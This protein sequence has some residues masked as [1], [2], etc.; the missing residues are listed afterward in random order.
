M[1]AD[2]QLA[3]YAKLTLQKNLEGRY[4]ERALRSRILQTIRTDPS[5]AALVESGAAQLREWL[6]SG[7]DDEKETRL[8]PIHKM[9]LEELTADVFV[10]TTT[11]FRPETL[12]GVASRV[13]HKLGF[14]DTADAVKTAAEIIT[15]LSY[16]GAFLL[17]KPSKYAQWFVTNNLAMPAE[18]I[19]MADRVMFIL[20]M[21]SRPEPI[22][23]A[24]HS[25]YETFNETV[26]TGKAELTHK[27]EIGIDV[28]NTQNQVA[29]SIDEEFL[30]VCEEKPPTDLDDVDDA[31]NVDFTGRTTKRENWET[32]RKES[33]TAYKELIE[34]GN[35]FYMT[36]KPDQ[37]LRLYANGYHINPQGRPFKKAMLN[38]HKK[39]VVTG[40]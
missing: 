5:N 14:A 12:V 31:D 27:G 23:S 20:P 34:C 17:Q 6:M 33:L 36:W 8:D 19:E 28:I 7:F 29:L 30:N 26:M 25:P 24:Y 21:V 4:S 35:K 2:T 11:C 22:K 9:D 37:R 13:A 10:I 40:F 16:T 38:F 18:V 39:E 15:I 32:F 3:R 1:S